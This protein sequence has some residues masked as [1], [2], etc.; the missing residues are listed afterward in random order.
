MA[1]DTTD[2]HT[3]SD[4]YDSKPIVDRRAPHEEYQYLELIRDI[5]D[6]GEHRPDRYVGSPH[7]TIL[8][9]T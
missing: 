9:L 4:H 2:T 7:H 3:M 1:E 8:C 6:Y 5:L